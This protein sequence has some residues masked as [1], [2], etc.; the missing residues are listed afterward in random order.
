MEIGETVEEWRVEAHQPSSPSVGRALGR[1]A[2]GQ[3]VELLWPTPASSDNLTFFRSVHT[4]SRA[5]HPTTTVLGPA[6]R[7]VA[8]R[9]K[10][11]APTFE[12][13]RPPFEPSVVAAIGRELAPAVLQPG[14][15][16]GLGLTDFGIDESGRPVFAP[17]GGPSPG[18]KH[19]PHVVLASVLFWLLTGERG[20][21]TKVG[22]D[23]AALVPELRDP[24][25]RL[26]SGDTLDI[27]RALEAAS[28][29]LPDLREHADV[30]DV[31]APK[32]SVSSDSRLGEVKLTTGD[33]SKVRRARRD[34][35]HDL[36]VLS[37]DAARALGP[38][39]RS[40]IAGELRIDK[41]VI[42]Q[43]IAQGAALPLPD[44]VAIRGLEGASIL[45]KPG[46]LLTMVGVVALL[47]AAA[48]FVIGLLAMLPL[49]L[50]VGGFLVALSLVVGVVGLVPLGAAIV[51]GMSYQ[52]SV[53]DWHKLADARQPHDLTDPLRETLYEA[54]RALGTS[55]LPD[56]AVQDLRASLD[57]IEE[58]LPELERSYDNEESERNALRGQVSELR[59]GAAEIVQAATQP[60]NLEAEHTLDHARTALSHARRSLGALKSSQG[61]LSGR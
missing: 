28:G 21:P 12:Q 5:G 6:S 37:P 24:I 57:Q 40:R 49:G 17:L 43:A 61:A 39:E 11:A 35:P 48:I 44:S 3:A 60:A 53:K 25:E 59:A 29:S 45:K 55:E 23:R 46:L 38:G 22:M 4:S 1:N 13:L 15:P 27:H 30:P 10:L 52:R 56:L 54:R 16:D 8:V 33:A 34:A 2:E 19:P 36:I 18:L 47:G 32:A 58:I 42:D 50:I 26:L 7:P 20:P 9:P 31:A 14:L 51:K 41:A